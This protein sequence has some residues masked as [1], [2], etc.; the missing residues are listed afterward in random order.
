VYAFALKGRNAGWD[1][2]CLRRRF[3]DGGYIDFISTL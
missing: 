1:F 2:I 3:G